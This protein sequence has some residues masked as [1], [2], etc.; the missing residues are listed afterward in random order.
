MQIQNYSSTLSGRLT[1]AFIVALL[2]LNTSF[3]QQQKSLAYEWKI[4]N[5]A[6]QR[7][8]AETNSAGKVKVTFLLI[9][10][11]GASILG[12][13]WG[14]YLNAV[15]KPKLKPST[16]LMYDI[17]QI[18]GDLHYIYPN[19]NF[20]E[21]APGGTHEMEFI[22][23]DIRNYTEL[24]SGFYL[25][26]KDNPE[27]GF[28]LTDL[29]EKPGTI[30]PAIAKTSFLNNTKIQDLKEEKLV[31]VFPTPVSYKEVKGTFEINSKT[32]IIPDHAFSA[33]AIL[34]QKDLQNLLAAQLVVDEAQTEK[35]ALKRNGNKNTIILRK[36]TALGK[37][38]TLNVSAQ[39]I[40]ICSGEVSGIFYGIQSLKT[41]LD[42]EYYT[43]RS[44]KIKVQGVAILDSARFQHRSLLMDVA[45]N[46]LPKQEVIKTLDL[47]ALYKLNVL[48][49]HLNDDEGWRIE[50]PG[51]PELTEIGSKR[52]YTTQPHQ[53]LPPSYGSGPDVNNPAGSGFY[54]R[55]D[56]R[57]ILQYAT[58]RHIKVIPE[59]E[60]PGHARAAIK[61]MDARYAKYI[62]L[63]DT[64]EANRYLLRDLNDKSSYRSVQGWNDNV[65][66]VAMPS[67]YR[68]LEKVTTEIVKIY[69]EA[70]APLETIHMGGDEVP[71]GVWINSPLVKNLQQAEPTLKDADDLWRYYFNKTNDILKAHQLYLYGWEEVDLKHIMVA[72]RRKLVPDLLLQGKNYQVD[73]WNNIIGTGAEDLAYRL[74]NNG[75]RV[76]LSN[77]TN[78]YL[79]M[80]YNQSFNEHGMNWAGFVDIDKPF[81]F[82]PFDY[83]KSITENEMAEPVSQEFFRNKDTLQAVNR[84]NIAGLQAA[85]WSETITDTLTFEYLL[86]PKL[87]A[88]AERSWAQHPKWASEQTHTLNSALYHKAWSEFIHVTGKRE[89]PRLEHYHNGYSYRIPEPG[90]WLKE[91]S[92]HA[93]V[94]FPEMIIR[95]TTDG[96]VPDENS[97]IYSQPV[98]ERG[99]LS[100][101]VFTKTGRSGKTVV[102]VNQP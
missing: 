21:L 100:F 27:K 81:N 19:K 60:T 4:D 22:I 43:N 91:G 102:I 31:R 85:L 63:G 26:K 2:S 39:H 75:F 6:D 64:A 20:R 25:V 12:T 33:E 83:Y 28:P 7:S 52:G 10:K 40:V 67:T 55:A 78:M 44:Q 8:A 77:V 36:D 58:A 30:E 65:I 72:G 11:T 53:M 56:F 51:L 15:K 74:A 3:A 88:F 101:K 5:A 37:A 14:I 84:K 50:I 76:V 79:D 48:H 29:S 13:D 93:N 59:I 97:K 89:L 69:R 46:F 95:Y 16:A 38:Y 92:I 71:V 96:S 61:S 35:T 1:V 62:A 42:P 54:N 17:K 18:N 82:I 49:F 80:A 57:E 24:P 23:P 34:L 73:V 87:L 98:T 90:V 94:Q 32:A 99:T 86:L 68:F 70:N 47:M 9:N 45:R 41:L 66:N